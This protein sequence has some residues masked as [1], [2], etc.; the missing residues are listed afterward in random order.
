MSWSYIS[1]A[2]SSI[3]LNFTFHVCF[4]FNEQMIYVLYFS[5]FRNVLRQCL[6]RG[7]MHQGEFED[8]GKQCVGMS[9][10]FLADLCINIPSDENFTSNTVDQILYNGDLLY[11]QIARERG[12]HYLMVSEIPDFISVQNEHL[13]ITKGQPYAGTLQITESNSDSLVYTLSDALS[14][15]ADLSHYLFVT[16]GRSPGYTSALYH[17]GDGNLLCFDSHSRNSRGES[18][19][20][21]TAVIL[22][23]KSF[24]AAVLYIKDLARS[25]NKD[26]A[27]FEITPAGISKR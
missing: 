25:L 3:L 14:N 22:K 7:S 4:T 8:G 11:K 24:D 5:H 9:L 18:S 23:I 13:E 2:E 27:Y 1:F 21:G 26:T 10:Q 17:Q 12:V 16:I 20:T 19:A 6:A 15:A